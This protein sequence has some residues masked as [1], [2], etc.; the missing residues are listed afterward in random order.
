[1]PFTRFIFNPKVNPGVRKIN[2]VISAFKNLFGI[3]QLHLTAGHVATGVW[4][5]TRGMAGL[6]ATGV[7]LVTWQQGYGWSHGNR[8]TFVHLFE[9][10]QYIAYKLTTKL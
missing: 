5:V 4:L 2:A 7:W 3:R 1:M 10:F 8:G 6:V 9:S